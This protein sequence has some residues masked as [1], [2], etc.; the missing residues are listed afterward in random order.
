MWGDIMN[1]VSA[2]ES[3]LFVVGD[4]GLS[5][6]E[7]KKILE[8]DDNTLTEITDKLID[9]YQN[10]DRGIEL[11]ILSNRLKLITKRENKQYLQKLVDFKDDEHLTDSA[12]ET[13]AIIAYNQPVTRI[14]VD[15]IRGVSSAYLVRKLVYKNLICEVGRS[16]AAGRPV[17]YG[18]TPLFLDYFGL[19]SIKDLPNIE[20]TKDDSVK[21]LYNSKYNEDNL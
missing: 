6:D 4:E 5:L 14:M 15:E 19:K 1:L 10:E 12:L 3:L 21:E 18:T 9:S 13:L 8:V 20:I 2:L 7:V 16:E 17:L 11:T